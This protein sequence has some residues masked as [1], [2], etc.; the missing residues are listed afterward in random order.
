M[1]RVKVKAINSAEIEKWM[2]ETTYSIWFE[3]Q[4]DLRDIGLVTYN[5]MQDFIN[6]NKTRLGGVNN[7]ANSITYESI[8]G[9]GSAMVGF[10]IGDIEVLNKNAPYWYLRNYGGMNPAE[11]KKVPGSFGGKAPDPNLAGTGVGHKRYEGGGFIM[12]PM[13]EIAPMNYI[14]NSENYFI[15][16]LA[17]IIPT[18]K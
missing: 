7:L 5:Y 13:S 18:F 2:E 6:S 17:R 15:S 9:P 14:E 11:G 8:G 1:I 3:A 12:V 4:S 10:Y 16:E